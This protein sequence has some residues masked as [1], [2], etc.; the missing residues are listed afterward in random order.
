M[1]ESLDEKKVEFTNI[2]TIQ[3]TSKNSNFLTR[4]MALKINFFSQN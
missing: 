2:F 3:Q 4:S 1:D